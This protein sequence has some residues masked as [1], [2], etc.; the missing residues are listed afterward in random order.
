MTLIDKDRF[1]ALSR[2]STLFFA[3]L[4]LILIPIG[5]LIYMIYNIAEMAPYHLMLSPLLFAGSIF[6]G[7]WIDAALLC[8]VCVFVVAEYRL[9]TEL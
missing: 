9:R 6:L 2:T 7:A 3:L 8:A 4:T 1:N 5:T